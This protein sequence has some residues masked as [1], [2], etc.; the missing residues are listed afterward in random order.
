MLK[1]AET[2]FENDF[3]VLENGTA[4]TY[5]YFISQDAENIALLGDALLNLAQERLGTRSGIPML[6]RAKK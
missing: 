4:R 6:P 2:K 3:S 5:D 1:I